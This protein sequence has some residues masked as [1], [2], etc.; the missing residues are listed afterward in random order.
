MAALIG[1]GASAYS[2]YYVQNP[3]SPAPGR[4]GSMKGPVPIVCPLR[5]G[6]PMGNLD[7]WQI[8]L[9]V[10]AGYVAVTALVRM[11]RLRRDTLAGQFRAQ[12][13]AGRKRKQ[14]SEAAEAAAAAEGEKAA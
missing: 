10:A 3:A 2:A 13:A 8:A 7:A 1:A 4:R 14:R 12:Y 11:M 6:S 9:L 5:E